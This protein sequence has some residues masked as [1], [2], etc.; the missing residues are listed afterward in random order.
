MPAVTKSAIKSQRL[1]V[2]EGLF[3]ALAT[4]PDAQL[5]NSR[6]VKKEGATLY[7]KNFPASCCVA[8]LAIALPGGA[9]G[10]DGLPGKQIDQ[11]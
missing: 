8:T 11:R 10:C 6:G 7:K 2:R 5:A 9:G 3:Q 4:G 1:N